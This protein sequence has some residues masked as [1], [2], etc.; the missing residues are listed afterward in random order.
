[1]FYVA[2]RIVFYTY[3]IYISIINYSLSRRRRTLSLLTRRFEIL[4]PKVEIFDLSPKER[5]A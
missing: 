2:I 1:M 4:Y 3:I 5:S